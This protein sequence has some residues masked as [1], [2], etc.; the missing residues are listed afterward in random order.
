MTIK[1]TEKPRHL[2]IG[3]GAIG[4]TLAAHLSQ[5]VSVDLAVRPS[6]LTELSATAELQTTDIVNKTTIQWPTP[7]LVPF[8][9]EAFKNGGYSTIWITTKRGQLDVI[10]NTL[11]EAQLTEGTVV[12]CQNGLGIRDK[13]TTCNG[14]V[15]NNIDIVVATIMF[16]ARMDSPLHSRLTTKAIIQLD[17]GDT[18][19]P[20]LRQQLKQAGFIVQQGGEAA[21]YG[22]LLINLNN[23]IGAATH[24][25]F[26]HMLKDQTLKQIYI[27]AV[28]EAVAVLNQAQIHY[29]LPFPLPYR[30]YRRLILSGGPLPV[31]IAKLK[32]GLSDE[33]YP[34]MDADLQLGRPTEI[35]QLNGE[36]V[37][38]GRKAAIATPVNAALY[39][40]IK[41]R[42]QGGQAWSEAQLQRYC[43]L[44]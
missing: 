13:L 16:N 32:N 4:T 14:L 20:T 26:M 44:A 28:D 8:T 27:A 7:R 6:R 37:R 36:I 41:I 15:T 18:P 29:E 23:A 31:W 39:R 9:A 33:A 12:A 3:P 34:S 1:T 38:L 10:L 40:A 11:S 42:E 25:T 19:K 21:I 22:K 43:G 2:I 5:I 17:E 35:D 24:T 30:A